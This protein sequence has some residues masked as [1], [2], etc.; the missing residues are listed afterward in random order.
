[1]KKAF[2]GP[3]ITIIVLV[4]LLA[5]FVYFYIQLN[6]QDKKIMTI[7]QTIAEDS[8]KINAIVNFFNTNPNA[9]TNQ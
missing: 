1:M 4:L 9:Q 5:M 3:L 2:V 6:R 8:G 7:Q